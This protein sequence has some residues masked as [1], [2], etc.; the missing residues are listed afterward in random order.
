MSKP[1]VLENPV[2]RE[3]Q[4]LV[5]AWK[6]A[7]SSCVSSS[8][9]EMFSHPAYRQIIAL[10]EPAVPFLLAELEREPDWWF[11]ALK[12]MTGADP[13]PAASRGKLAEMTRAWLQWALAQGYRW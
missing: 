12:A 11:A 6:A 4:G 2:E 8:L 1:K 5:R 10:G 13:V 7:S 3:F 9:S